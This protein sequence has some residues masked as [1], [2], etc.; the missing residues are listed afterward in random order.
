M[1]TPSTFVSPAQIVPPVGWLVIMGMS[2]VGGS[3]M[4]V[5]QMPAPLQ[6]AARYTI[7]FWAVDG[8]TRLV[9]SGEGLGDIMGNIV[10]L[11]V[12]GAVTIALAQVLLV[13][14]FREVS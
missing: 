11:L 14:R 2:A 1:L 10:R 5:E 7:N 12:I 3:M 13:R 8:Y 6:A 9:Y 4:P